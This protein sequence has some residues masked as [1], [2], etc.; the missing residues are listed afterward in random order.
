MQV[1][2][3]ELAAK[4]EA[5]KA[6]K[7]AEKAEKEAKK[8]ALKAEEDARRQMLLTQADPNDALRDMYGDAP[9]VQSRARTGKVWTEVSKLGGNLE[10]QEVL[11]RARLQAVRSKGKSAF[12]VLRQAT[13]TAQ[14]CMFVDDETV[15]KQMVKYASMIPKES[16]VDVGGLVVAS[17][18]ESCSQSD[19]EVQVREIR[20]ISRAGEVPFD[21]MDAARS[22]QEIDEALARGEKMVRVGQDTRLDNRVIDL[23]T[24]ANNAIFKIQSAVCQLFREAL[25]SRDFVEIHTPKLLSGA[26]E[27]GAAVFHVDYMGR[28]ACL[29]QSPQFYKQMAI[30]G[31]MARVFEIGSVFRAEDSNTHR[32]LTEFIGLDMEMSIYESYEEVLDVL[33]HLFVYMFQGLQG[34]FANELSVISQQYPVEPLEYL[35]QTLR[36]TFAE[37]IK[38]LHDAGHNVPPLDDLNTEME[39]TLGRLVKEKY[40]TDFYI[41]H[42]FPLGI[43][44]FYTMPDPEDPDYSASFDIFIRGEEIISG[45]QRVHDA[46]LLTQRAR[47]HG[48]PL[49]Q[50]QSYLDAFKCGCYPHGG[51]GVGLERVVMLFCGLN[52]IRK[53]GVD[54]EF[55]FAG[56]PVPRPLP[57]SLT[58]ALFVRSFVSFPD[59][60]VPSRPEAVGAVV[61][62]RYI[63]SLHCHHQ[64]PPSNSMSSSSGSGNRRI[65]ARPLSC[66]SCAPEPC[67][68]LSTNAVPP[69]P[70]TSSTSFSYLRRIRGSAVRNSPSEMRSVLMAPSSCAAFTCPG[71]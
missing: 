54:L 18:V 17:K 67:A 53:V 58:R 37:G 34:R 57:H 31:D 16:I 6:A 52:N 23:R 41:L 13:S 50:I 65:A 33:D 2:D 70:R 63:R 20:C 7:A 4:R 43:R 19:V 30:C 46:E 3:P 49:D 15:S 11:V 62:Q 47:E 1:V 56:I 39:R 24:P 28:P 66:S 27:G 29:A 12:L 9:M 22:D 42:K 61:S 38:M 68:L 51:A 35:P 44:P 69:P 40:K 55:D 71:P 5:K 14:A 48:I 25:L 60:D 36:I 21:V 10:G 32:H 64:Y 26:S 59:L 45:A 8:A